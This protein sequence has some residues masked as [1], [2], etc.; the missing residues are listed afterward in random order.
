MIFRA[1]VAGGAGGAVECVTAVLGRR[2]TVL[3]RRATA[4]GRRATVLG[5][6]ATAIGQSDATRLARRALTRRL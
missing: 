5:R 6:R 3:G 4:I 1:S 2:A